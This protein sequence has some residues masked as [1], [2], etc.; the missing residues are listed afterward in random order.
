V[1]I[2]TIL[3]PINTSLLLV[4]FYILL[5]APTLTKKYA[6]KIQLSRIKVVTITST[7][8]THHRSGGAIQICTVNATNNDAMKNILPP[9]DR[10][11]DLITGVFARYIAILV[12][13]ILANQIVGSF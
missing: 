11:T 2:S 7:C 4:N 12:P 13:G 6:T 1:D 5:H 9:S 3:A 8:T 10:A